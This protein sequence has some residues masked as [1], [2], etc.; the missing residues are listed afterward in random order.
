MEWHEDFKKSENK[1]M[2][3]FIVKVDLAPIFLL[4]SLRQS[5]VESGSEN[6]NEVKGFTIKKRGELTVLTF[7]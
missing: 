4:T 6:W 2:K 1:H 5:M 3:G 7:A